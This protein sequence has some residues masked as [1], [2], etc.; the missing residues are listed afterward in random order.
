VTGAVPSDGTDAV[1][2]PTIDWMPPL[3]GFAAHR[4]R[5]A[6]AA[7]LAASANYRKMLSA[8]R[9]RNHHSTGTDNMAGLAPGELEI[10]ERAGIPAPSVL[11]IATIIPARVMKD[12]RTT[13]DRGQRSRTR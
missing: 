7:G 3:R 10:Y 2:G 6:H 5:T 12:E 9:C 13:A 4:T 8:F 1:F 11:Q